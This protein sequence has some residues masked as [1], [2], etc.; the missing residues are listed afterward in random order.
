MHLGELCDQLLPVFPPSMQKDVKTA[1]GYLAKALDC[2]DPQHCPPELYTQSLTSL[3]R[4]IEKYQLTH[5]KSPHTLRNTKNAISRLFREAEYQHL[6]SLAPQTLTPR[7]P[8]ATKS[9]RPGGITTSSNGTYLPYKDWPAD[10]QQSFTDFKDWATAPVVRGRNASLRKRP[11]TLDDY[12]RHF[13]GYYGFLSHVQHVF[14]LTFEQLF[15][16]DLVSAFVHW[17]VN[18]LHYRPTKSI[19]IFLKQLLALTRQRY[20]LPEFRAQVAALRKTIPVPPPCYNKEDAWVPLA[21]LD[22]IGLALWP[23]KPPQSFQGSGARHPGL[24]SALHAGLS[25]M[26][27]LWCYRPYRQRNMREMQLDENLHKDAH[28]KWFITFRGEQLKVASKR[29]RS[30]EFNLQFPN[31]LVPVLEEYLNVWR[32]ILVGKAGHSSPYVFLTQHGTP[33][34]VRTLNTTTGAIVYRYT[35]KHW[36]PHIVRTVWATEW[37]RKTHGDFYTAA[38]MLNDKLETVIANYAHLLEE[39]V[40]EKADRLIHERNGQGK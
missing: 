8:I 3:Y 15:D 9:S 6:F 11:I 25:L 32:P 39:D 27:R 16:F 17:H 13:E 7:Y 31:A 5:G 35:G 20:L 12:R 4:R 22:E 23:S 10:L 36:H 26:F 24:M 2:A 34:N 40:A 37:I 21:K 33:Y 29:G 18:E 38:V 28:G 19:H 14:P 30:N 1:V